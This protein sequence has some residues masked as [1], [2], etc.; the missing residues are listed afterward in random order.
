MSTIANEITSGITLIK[1]IVL[2]GPEIEWIILLPKAN[3]AKKG[4]LCYIVTDKYNLYH[5]HGIRIEGLSLRSKIP[6]N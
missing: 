5:Q 3:G 2:V 6:A 1:D 4:S